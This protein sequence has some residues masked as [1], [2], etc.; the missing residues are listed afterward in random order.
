METQDSKPSKKGYGKRPTWQ[1]IVGYVI[2][3][4]VVY[5]VIYYLFVHHGGGSTTSSNMGY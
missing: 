3:A 2:I 1:W 4:I 5:G